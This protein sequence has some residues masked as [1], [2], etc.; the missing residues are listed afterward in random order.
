MNA[1]GSDFTV[2][3]LFSG[4]GAF[5]IAF[6]RAGMTTVWQSEIDRQC[7]EVLA[8]HWP[9]VEQLGDVRNVGRS[10]RT[11]DLIC[12]GFPCTDLSVAGK[13]KGLA[14]EQSGLW[15]EFHRVLEE[16]KPRWCVIENVTG[17]LSSGERRD[18]AIILQGLAELGYLSAWRVF[19]AQYA[20]V[21]QRRRR[22]FIVGYSGDGRA[23]EVLFESTG[24]AWDPPPSREKRQTV[25]AI[26][27]SGAGTSRTGNERT[28]AQ[29]LVA[30]PLTTRPYA[31]NEAQESRLVPVIALTLT[32][33]IADGNRRGWAPVNEADALIVWDNGQGDPNAE[34]SGAS[35]SLNP[36]MNQGV[37]YALS[38][39]HGRNSGEDTFVAQFA[40]DKRPDTCDNPGINHKG[41]LS[42]ASAQETNTREA[43]SALRQEIGAEAFAEWG[44]GVLDS[45]QQTK[46]LRPPLHGAGIRGKAQ[47]GSSGVDNG[48][49]SCT[50]DSP[51][52]AVREVCVTQ[53]LRRTSQRWELAQQLTS[54]LGAYLSQLSQPGPSQTEALHDLWQASEG[55]GVLRQALSEIQEAWRSYDAQRQTGGNGV[56]LGVR[57]LTP[58]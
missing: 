44:L 30:C 47:K 57:R 31:D 20:G 16:L 51:T 1:A 38:A 19:D 17:L 56:R 8:H 36:Q 2:G 58:L 13:R 48:P 29:M 37:C 24:R 12:G 10:S 15:F 27:A 53:C 23:A 33:T 49:L 25:A 39:H 18:F 22:V 41:D 32:R 35:Y 42:D 28:E 34:A 21:A 6:G 50:E 43:L 7:L 26:S 14:G 40:F 45:L 52:R 54:E 3:S 46:V 5:E 9:D 4:V 55:I 11:V